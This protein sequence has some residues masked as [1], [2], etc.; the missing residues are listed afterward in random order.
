M[1][2]LTAVTVIAG[3]KAYSTGWLR[4]G[5][6]VAAPFD[7]ENLECRSDA[8]YP[9]TAPEQIKWVLCQGQPAMVLFYSTRCRPCMMMDALVQMVKPDYR[10]R[11]V[12]I[13]A[14]YDDPANAG[15]LRWARVGTIPASLFVT[16]TGEVK[17]VAGQMNQVD[18]RVELNRLAAENQD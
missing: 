17:Q 10:E 11:V 13:E 18:L 5:G 4:G 7:T 16:R 12:F 14:R 1:L 3:V 2:V 6:V 8:P 9:E 15:L